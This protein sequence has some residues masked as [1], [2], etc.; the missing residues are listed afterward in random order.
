MAIKPISRLAPDM[1][2]LSS[3]YLTC[4]DGKNMVLVKN[5]QFAIL[6]NGTDYSLF[7]TDA[8]ITWVAGSK[9]DTGALEPGKD[10]YVYLCTADGLDATI[11]ESANATCPLGYNADNS[12]KIGGYHTLCLGVGTIAGHDLSGF[13]AGDV[14]PRSVW[15]LNHRPHGPVEGRFYD[16]DSGIWAMIYLASVSGGELVS[17]YNGVTADGASS[18]TFHW[19]KFDQWLRRI[20]NRMP[21]QGEFVSLS[22]GSNQGTNIVGSADPVT[23]GGHVDTTGRR[24][25]SNHG[26]EDCCGALWQWGIEAEAGGTTSWE[27]A[28]DGNDT[29][30]AGQ[31]YLAPN[32]ALFGG[33]WDSGA[34]CG[35][36]S[37]AWNISPLFLNAYL[38]VRGVAEPLAGGR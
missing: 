7:E 18:E 31:H 28:Y 4:T 8:D 9:L 15:C 37:S 22:L 13:V 12:R 38:G 35:S 23:T 33:L 29:G 2:A 17:V 6:Y 24:M 10:Y 20:G 30:V 16:P 21:F 26:A 27:N 34:S 11:K 1:R 19:Y 36:R 3:P 32:R 5:T 25:I 14:L